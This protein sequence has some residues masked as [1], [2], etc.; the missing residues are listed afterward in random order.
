[1]YFFVIFSKKR[2]TMQKII[3]KLSDLNYLHC[4]LAN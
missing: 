4:S 3:T 1:M 2:Q